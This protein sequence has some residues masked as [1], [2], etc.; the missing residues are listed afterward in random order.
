MSEIAPARSDADLDA[1]K[2][3]FREYVDDLD[4]ALDFQDFDAEL[5][6]FPGK[7]GPPT[8]ALLLA[9]LDG[10]PVG[11]VGLR[12][13]GDGICEMKRLYLR[14]A[15]RGSGL[16]TRLV[17]AVIAE[18]R[19]LGYRAM[20]LDTVTDAQP[21]AIAIYRARGFREIA[22]YCVNPLPTATFLELDLRQPGG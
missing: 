8:G 13:L 21:R 16:G 5:A 7:Y 14:P 2:A 19:R 15:A 1:V 11:V 9:K 17:D 6:E 12:A 3:L 20:R 10:R 4:F 22:P 18:A